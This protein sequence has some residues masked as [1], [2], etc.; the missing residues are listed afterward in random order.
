VF[1]LNAARVI[2]FFAMGR[3]Q[4]W[5]HRLS[6]LVAFELMTAAAVCGMGFTQSFLVMVL[7]CTFIGMNCG[8]AFFAAVSYSLADPARKHARCAINE[9]MVGAGSFAG[10]TVFG[11]LAGW[12]GTTMPFRWGPVILLIGI[13]V[14][15][16]V[17]HV[18]L[19]RARS[20][21]T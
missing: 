9:T 5:R 6:V 20:A 15:W 10:S 11:L 4:R 3:T 14:Q 1:T 17:L 13:A 18:S 19:R 21:E 12:Y 2:V 16:A 7:C 8:V